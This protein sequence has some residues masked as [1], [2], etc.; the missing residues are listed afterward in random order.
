MSG[1]PAADDQPASPRDEPVGYLTL[2]A[3]LWLDSGQDG[4]R[5]RG[6]LTDA[7][8]GA[9]LPLDLTDLV[10]FLRHSLQHTQGEPM[11]GPPY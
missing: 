8:T 3:R 7:H 10:A 2:V 5:I 1:E 9:Q 11:D 6:S 4:R